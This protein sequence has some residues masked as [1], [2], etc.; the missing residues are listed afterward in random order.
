MQEAAMNRENVF[1][2]ILLFVEHSKHTESTARA[3]LIVNK[4]LAFVN[5]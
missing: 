5:F 1:I 4:A 2:L 3:D